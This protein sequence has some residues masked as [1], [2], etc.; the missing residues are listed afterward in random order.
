MRDAGKSPWLG[1]GAA[2]GGTAVL[3]AALAPLR[4]DVG[5]L[6]VGLLFLLLTLLISS[7]WGLLAGAFAAVVTNLALNFFFIEPL[8]AF[9]VRH[10]QNVIGLVIFL[11]VSVVGGSLLSAER[12]AAGRA[13]RREAETQVLLRLSRAMI[14]QTDP[15]AALHALCSE[16]ISAF[17]AAGASV[18]SCSS[19]DWRVLAAAG[20]AAAHRPVSREEQL[21]AE[22]TLA[23]GST[24]LLGD[25]GFEARRRV[26]IVRPRGSRRGDA[27]A[28]AFVPLQVGD[29]VLG[30]LRLDGP[31]GRDT[32][33]LDEPVQLLSA[34]AGEAALGVQ[35]VELARGA[36]HAEVLKQADEMKSALMASI[37]H[38]LKTPLAGIKTAVS[39][40]LDEQV[41]WTDQ[42]RRSFLETIDSQ[43]DR[44]DR[45]ITDILDLTRIESGARAAFLTPVHL[46]DLLAEACER[47]S[48][49]A[50]ARRTSI[51]VPGDVYVLADESLLLHAIVNLIENAA[52]YS[53][54]GGAIRLRAI[55]GAEAVDVIVEDE[56]PGIDPRDLP[57]IFDRFYRGEAQSRRVRGSGLGLAIVKGF[58]EACGG[59]VRVESGP[60][61]TRF[62]VTMPAAAPAR[63]MT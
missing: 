62:V 17:G 30:V 57:H 1:A 31:A 29:R 20:D 21:M 60:A 44:L 6:N 4:G 33:P 36:A 3:V 56:G 54:E 18:L 23:G 39:S 10:P 49:I 26:R 38:D 48:P 45:V 40:L 43:A 13:R 9:T 42:D 32:R 24:R 35:R 55:R 22:Q 61:C 37:S 47:I 34:F 19:G 7:R 15:D 16:V 52:K 59:T 25:P 46:E 27:A 53:R 58:V 8:H 2:V 28:M 63:V 12:E 41:R 50:D 5:L 14:G 51:T 11:I